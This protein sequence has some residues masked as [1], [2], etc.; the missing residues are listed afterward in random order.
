[1][2]STSS[3]RFPAM[4][5]VLSFW[6]ATN[7]YSPIGVNLPNTSGGLAPGGAC[8]RHLPALPAL[9]LTAIRN[10]QIH[11]GAVSRAYYAM[12]H[13]AGALLLSKGMTFSKH[14]AAISAFGQEHGR[15]SSAL[16]PH[17]RRDRATHH[18]RGTL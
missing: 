13:V 5:W 6:T 14:S 17:G 2:R 3:A 1:M 4:T 18:P 9:C 16:P 10:R 15:P 12:F 8:G 7:Q 11:D